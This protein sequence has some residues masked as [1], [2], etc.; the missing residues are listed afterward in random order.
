[1]QHCGQVSL[2]SQSKSFPLPNSHMLFPRVPWG[3][4]S[5]ARLSLSGKTDQRNHFLY[6]VRYELGGQGLGLSLGVQAPPSNASRPSVVVGAA[7]TAILSH[8]LKSISTD[9]EH[10]KQVHSYLIGLSSAG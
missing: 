1:M 9:T 5:P 7:I 10:R 3:L 6:S 4:G 8:T 2:V